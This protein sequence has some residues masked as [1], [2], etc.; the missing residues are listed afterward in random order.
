[1]DKDVQ[2][3][4]HILTRAR[5]K[6]NTA[7][8]LSR[9]DQVILRT[10]TAHKKCARQFNENNVITYIFDDNSFLRIEK[11]TYYLMETG[12]TYK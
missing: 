7:M 4:R 6:M 12:S 3:N 10:N 8:Q 2:Y 5:N 9:I 1:M 11:N